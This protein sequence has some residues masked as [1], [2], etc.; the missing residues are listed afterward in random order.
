M[1][2]VPLVGMF[3]LYQGLRLHLRWWDQQPAYN[4][5]VVEQENLDS[6]TLHVHVH[7]FCQI[8]H[9]KISLKLGSLP[10]AYFCL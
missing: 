6:N 10:L 4:V 3:D 9:S 8:R 5:H 1:Y 2:T 7:T